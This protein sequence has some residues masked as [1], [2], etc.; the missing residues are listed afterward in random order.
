MTGFAKTIPKGTIIEIQFIA[1][2]WTYTHALPRNTKH[3]AID[4]QVCFHRRLIADPVKPPRS[5]TGYVSLVNG[6]NKDMSGARL[7]QMIVS[8]YPV[9]WVSFGHLLKI[10]HCCLCPNGGYNQPLATH[11]PPPPTHPHHPPT[12]YNVPSVI[13]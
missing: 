7:L 5:P 3:I 8:T 6:I 2:Y 11:L 12:P 13:L 1:D 4:G 10:Q 9:G